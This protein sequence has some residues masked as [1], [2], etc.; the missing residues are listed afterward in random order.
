MVLSFK[1]FGIH[2]DNRKL[3][4]N[5]SLNINRNCEV[6]L[7]SNNKNIS[8]ITGIFT[9]DIFGG[10]RYSGSVIHNGTDLIEL[11]S[12]IKKFRIKG[13]RI[14][15][16]S[17]IL[18][19]VLCIPSNP[20][21]LFDPGIDIY[22]QFLDFIPYESRIDV[23]NSVIRREMIKSSDIESVIN[24][25]DLS[26]QK[27]YFTLSIC[28]DFG[29]IGIYKEIYKTLL[30]GGSDRKDKLTYLIIGRKTG[31]NLA[32]MVI[33]R[34]YYKYRLNLELLTYEYK[35]S[36]IEMQKKKEFYKEIKNLKR[37]SGHDFDFMNLDLTR[38]YSEGVLKYELIENMAKEI[39]IMGIPFD[40][41]LYHRFPSEIPVSD[42][43]KFITGIGFITEKSLIIAD[44]SLY[45]EKMIEISEYIRR[46]KSLQPITSLYLCS[47]DNLTEEAD[48][49]FDKIIEI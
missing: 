37:S 33:L 30:S 44:M 6:L 9:F 46:M 47:H 28:R 36:I 40:V 45:P 34:D 49:L 23:I 20:L 26:D 27:K 14:G 5:I 42:I 38:A 24:N 43:Y 41:G 10:Y 19:D 39:N 29:I 16:T 11:I 3:I 32:D 2:A 8:L 1:N 35:K 13:N 7:A 18:N 48:K 31:V 21:D 22:N 17:H 12:N 4:D 25:F 15:V